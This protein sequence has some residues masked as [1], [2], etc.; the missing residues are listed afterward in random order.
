MKTSLLFSG[1]IALTGTVLALGS[2]R[3]QEPGAGKPQT[4][5]A[6]AP[7]AATQPA[8]PALTPEQKAVVESVQAFARAYSA[9]DSKALAGFFTEDVV[10]TDPEGNETRGR[11]SIAEMYSG[12]FQE[13]PGLKLEPQ[14]TEVRFITPDVARVEGQSRLSSSGDASEFTR[15][16]ALLVRKDGKWQAA[17]IREFP[18]PA[19]DIAPYD[20]LKELE[21]MVG[22]WVDDNGDNRVEADVRWADNNSYL[23]RTYSTQ[24]QGEKPA[25]GTM[26]IGWDPQS[27]QIKSWNFDS[28]G[29]HG[30]GLW[31]RTSENEWV[32]K[33]NGVL[34][35]GRPNSATLVHTILNKDSVKTNSLD[36]IIGGQVAP[37][38]TDVVMVRQPP[39]PGA[40]AA[41]PATN[42]APK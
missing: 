22:H 27:G 36:R 29:G 11:A 2:P 12:A 5:P 4:K 25:S 13:N 18:A 8:A 17:E 9:A 41:K 16:S 15:F 14:V 39:Q 31:T 19:E 6:A 40:S 32:V 23:I 20:R 26:F 3:A 35:D 10:L 21:W 38:I 7:P 33:A 28:A 1:A 30:E 24:I 34:R 37:D 42:T